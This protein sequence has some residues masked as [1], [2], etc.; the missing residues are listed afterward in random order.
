MQPIVIVDG[1]NLAQNKYSL[2]GK[3]VTIQY[4]R[5]L[6]RD[7][8]AWAQRQA[9]ACHVDLFLDPR[10]LIPEGTSRVFLHVAEPGERADPHIKDY[11]R[12]CVMSKKPCI[13]ITDDDDLTEYANQQG[14]GVIEVSEFIKLPNYLNLSPIDFEK[15]AYPYLQDGNTPAA[16]AAPP[17]SNAIRKSANQPDRQA[18]KRQHIAAADLLDVHQRTYQAWQ[19]GSDQDRQP[20]SQAQAPIRALPPETRK[21]VRLNFETW[22]LEDGFQFFTEVICAQH[23]R[24]YQSLLGRPKQAS[25]ADLV[26]YYQFVLE[27]CGE[28]QDFYT[29]GASL[30]NKVRLELMQIYPGGLEL[31]GLYE[32][33]KEHPG[34]HHK[35]QLHSGKSIELYEISPG[36]PGRAA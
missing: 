34:F 1:N 5:K 20:G 14:A 16:K 13:V 12:H 7:L 11:V 25:R 15:K 29:R 18:Q 6:I 9:E 2:Q 21:M 33:H 31:A 23:K 22:P 10:M 26:T 17:P 30:M 8:S 3:P 27:V 4:D 35:I 28:E 32:K 36:E 19:V 24:E